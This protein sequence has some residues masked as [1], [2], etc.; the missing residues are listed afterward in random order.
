MEFGEF[1]HFLVVHF[2]SFDGVFGSEGVAVSGSIAL[3]DSVWVGG[4]V[5]AALVLK[6]GV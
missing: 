6:L 2:E 3:D 5:G 1:G 4:G